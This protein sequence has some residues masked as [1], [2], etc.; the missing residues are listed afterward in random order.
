MNNAEVKGML[1]LETITSTKGAKIN[2]PKPIEKTR[3][4]YGI[5]LGNISL[6]ALNKFYKKLI[7]HKLE[8]SNLSCTMKSNIFFIFIK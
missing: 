7:P 4:Q 3:T 6:K 5:I 8:W 2:Q 1:N